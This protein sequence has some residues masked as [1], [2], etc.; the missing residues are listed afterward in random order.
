VADVARFGHAVEARTV[1]DAML[2]PASIRPDAT[3]GEAFRAMH[4][5]RLSGL[6]VV[7][8]DGRPIGYLDL[9]ELAIAYLDAI[10]AEQRATDNPAS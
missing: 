6:Y 4:Q 2:E 10:E 5:R 1:A 3:I 7:D 9:I 8:P